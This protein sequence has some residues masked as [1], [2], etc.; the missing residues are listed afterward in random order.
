MR[1]HSMFRRLQ[2]G[3]TAWNVGPEEEVERVY[4]VGIKSVFFPLGQASL[5]LSH[6]LGR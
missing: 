1:E 5:P 4:A 6:A 3:S 2:S